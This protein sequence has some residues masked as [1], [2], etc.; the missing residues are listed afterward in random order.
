M[1]TPDS[2]YERVDA[3]VPEHGQDLARLQRNR[4]LIDGAPRAGDGV[5]L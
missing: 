4:I 3:R 1:D 5:L 2:Y